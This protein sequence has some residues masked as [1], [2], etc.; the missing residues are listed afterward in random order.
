[1][2][3]ASVILRHPKVFYIYFWEC[4][5]SKIFCLEIQRKLLLAIPLAPSMIILGV[6]DRY[7]PMATPPL[8]LEILLG[9]AYIYHCSNVGIVPGC[10]G[11]AMFL[12][13]HID[14]E[15]HLAESTGRIEFFFVA[16]V[17][18]C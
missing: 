2:E 16:C 10:E 6:Y 9:K 15:L 13:Q 8:Q 12:E 18:S 17:V 4:P 3:H 1:M 14:V 5:S 7:R 11:L